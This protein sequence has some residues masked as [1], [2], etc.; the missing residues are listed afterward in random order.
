MYQLRSQ[1]THE[2]RSTVH[3]V[4]AARAV[5]ILF[6]RKFAVI[7]VDEKTKAYVYVCL[8][9]RVNGLEL[10]KVCTTAT[11]VKNYYNYSN[12]IMHV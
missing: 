5:K 2:T 12:I 7:G 4:C 8:Y 11:T 1:D 9:T 6:R 3:D 10:L